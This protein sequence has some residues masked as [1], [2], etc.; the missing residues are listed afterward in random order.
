LAVY[1]H[2]RI[3]CFENCRLQYR[4]RYIDRIK[5]DVEGIEAF[6]GK[7]VHEVLE[8]LYRDLPAARSMQA[9]DFGERF[10]A[11]W[12]ERLTSAVRIV[13]DEKTP[14]SYRETGR[15]CVESYHRRHHPFDTGEVVGCET[16][17][18]F[19]LDRQGLY[20]MQGYIDRID[21]V[22]SD[23]L[24]I[25]DYKT[26]VLPREGALKRDRQLSLYEIALRQRHT[27]LREVRQVW[28]YLAHDRT[29][30]ETRTLDE[31]RRT[32]V[33][34]IHAIQTI[35]ATADFV[36]RRSPLC[37]WCDYKDICPE[38]EEERAALPAAVPAPPAGVPTVIAEPEPIAAEAAVVTAADPAEAPP[39]PR[40]VD[41]ATG[42]YRLFG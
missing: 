13:R 28:H 23:V 40:A 5:R 39:P 27:G 18:E 15:E 6:M 22:G 36:P 19:S 38:W 8:G 33:D 24:E 7:I 9:G 4:Y 16:Q 21:R 41:T 20:R 2:S 11:L 31:L 14:E 29:F 34:T 17:V 30:V 42:Q 35:E 37:S 10:D 3:S 12:R 25:H 1:S 26:G 32:G